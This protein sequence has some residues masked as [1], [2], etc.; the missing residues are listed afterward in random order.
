MG[1]GTGWV[2]TL[3]CSPSLLPL[4]LQLAFK[5]KPIVVH[6]NNITILLLITDSI[7]NTVSTSF[8][9]YRMRS[10]HSLYSATQRTGKPY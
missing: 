6:I 7:R 1:G 9:L 4:L 8:N 2:K 5:P 3:A 10:F